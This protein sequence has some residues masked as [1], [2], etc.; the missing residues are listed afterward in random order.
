MKRTILFM[1]AAAITVSCSD[2]SGMKEDSAVLGNKFTVSA[3]FAGTKAS[4]SE[5]GVATWT[6]GDQLGV[7]VTDGTNG[8]FEAFTLDEGCAGEASGTFTATLQAGYSIGDVAVYPYNSGH[9]LNGNSLTFHMAESYT[10]NGANANMPM[11]GRK[12]GN[13]FMLEHIGGVV[14]IGF[15]T[16]STGAA[17]MKVSASSAICGDFVISDIT[18]EDPLSI[19]TTAS[20]TDAQKTV[21]LTIANLPEDGYF[22]VP[23]PCG[24]ISGLKVSLVDSAEGVLQEKSKSS[25]L[26]VNRGALILMPEIANPNNFTFVNWG[27]NLGANGAALTPLSK[28]ANQFRAPHGSDKG[29]FNIVASDIPAGRKVTYACEKPSTASGGI[30]CNASGVVTTYPKTAGTA[31]STLGFNIV[32]VTVGE[33]ELAVSKKF[34]L[35][36]DFCGLQNG[37]EIY[38]SPLAVRCNPKTGIVSDAPLIKNAEGTDVSSSVALDFSTNQVYW[39]LNGPASHTNEKM[40]KNDSDK[41]SFLVNLWTTYLASF[42]KGWNAYAADPMSWWINNPKNT[43]DRCGAYLDGSNGMRPHV[44]A[45]KFKDANGVYGDGVMYMT[46]LF[47]ASGANPQSASD[48]AQVNRLF[49]WFD[50]DYVEESI[51]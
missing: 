32:K 14:R 8:H 37:Y 47:S 7:Y 31:A 51:N 11:V 46:L 44:N 10:V 45:D 26:V 4:V 35:F 29:K 27:N 19:S 2:F 25:A 6:A 17:T 15:Q 13:K 40:L 16:M 3:E 50:T 18:S 49:L 20:A 5:E 21:A 43:L 36:V 42:N 33:G 48:K 24:S 23:V 12:D 41:T 22:Y 28:Y 1:L 34:P 38:F 9:A 30:D 39:N